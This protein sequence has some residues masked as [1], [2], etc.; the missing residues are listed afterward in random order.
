MF[1][2]VRGAFTGADSDKKGRIL[3]ADGGT[4]FIDEINSATPALQLK[5]LR[6]LQEKQFEPVGSTKTVQVDVRFVLA[7]NEPLQQ[8]VA[9]GRFRED[10]YYRINVVN[11]ELPLLSERVGDIP[12]L[13]WLFKH[14]NTNKTRTS[15]IVFVTPQLI[16]SPEEVDE[17]IRR[18][19][20]EREEMVEAER[21]AIFG[22]GK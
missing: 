3:A 7:S 4:L 5:L 22:G 19:M 14:K 10:L 17:N 15:L 1:G 8:L 13:G 11:I 21:R 12:L 18:M 6:V 9:D 2:H 16:R 20:R